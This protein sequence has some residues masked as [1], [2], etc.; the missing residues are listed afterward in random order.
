MDTNFLKDGHPFY[1]GWSP[2]IPM[3]VKHHAQD[4]D[5]S[6]KVIAVNHPQDGH[7]LTIEWST[8]IPEM[9]NTFNR[10]VTHHIQDG[11]L[12]LEFDSSTG[13]LV[14]SKLH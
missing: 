3:M 6:S 14:N 11:Q 8:T 7:P 9:V 10:T 4:G 5:T 12:D 13:Q 1:K 2:T